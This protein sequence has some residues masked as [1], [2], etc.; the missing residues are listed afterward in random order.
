M[1]F[2]VAKYFWSKY[3]VVSILEVLFKSS[4]IDTL[5]LFNFPFL[6][7]TRNSVI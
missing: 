7:L 1:N 5:K 2:V 3:L 4:A 6:D